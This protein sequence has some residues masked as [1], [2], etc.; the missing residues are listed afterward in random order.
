MSFVFKKKDIMK[1]FLFALLSFSMIACEKASLIEPRS[2][3]NLLLGIWEYEMSA[4]LNGGYSQTYVRTA[5]LK[6]KNCLIFEENNVFKSYDHGFCGT[7]P[8]SFWATEGT[9]ARNQD[10]I[11]FDI[12]HYVYEGKKIEIIELTTEKLTFRFVD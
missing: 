5:E 1:V 8:L 9:Y 6:E 7:P 4:E 11:S 2:E 12:K 3:N 10:I